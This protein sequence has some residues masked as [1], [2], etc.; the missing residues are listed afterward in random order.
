MFWSKYGIATSTFKLL[1][2]VIYRKLG[3][4]VNLTSREVL[5]DS[6]DCLTTVAYSTPEEDSRQMCSLRSSNPESFAAIQNQFQ[7]ICRL[8]LSLFSGYAP[9]WS[10]LFIV[11]PH[12]ATL[13]HKRIQRFGALELQETCMCMDCKSSLVKSIPCSD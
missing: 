9:C 5:C 10:A 13:G 6:A 3:W 7:N 4:R 1:Y 12:A 2:S 8:I 11:M